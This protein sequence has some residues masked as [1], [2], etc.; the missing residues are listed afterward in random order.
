MTGCTLSIAQAV[1]S[2]SPTKKGSMFLITES[3][4]TSEEYG[5]TLTGMKYKIITNLTEGK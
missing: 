4:I 1:I 2:A 5:M 3:I